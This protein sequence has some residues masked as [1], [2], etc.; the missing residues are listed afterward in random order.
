MSR[1]KE[2]KTNV[3][4]PVIDTINDETFTLNCQAAKHT[5]AGGHTWGLIFT[6]HYPPEYERKRREYKDYLPM[7]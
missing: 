4:V 3:V 6:W 1:I 7:R 5:Q 2:N